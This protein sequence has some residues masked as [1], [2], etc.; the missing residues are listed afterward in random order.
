M[1]LSGQF[2]TK[3][4]VSD[5]RVRVAPNPTNLPKIQKRSSV[6]IRRLGRLEGDATLLA[7][8]ELLYARFL[9]IGENNDA[10][11]VPQRL[12]AFLPFETEYDSLIRKLCELYNQLNVLEAGGAA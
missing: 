3:E 11:P 9:E 2:N 10:V 4:I 6:K 8:F 7:E 5:L 12:S 1:K